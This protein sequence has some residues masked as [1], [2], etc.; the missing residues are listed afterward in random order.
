VRAG[1]RFSARTATIRYAGPDTFP[2][3]YIDQ[4]ACGYYD[5]LSDAVRYWRLAFILTPTTS[6]LARRVEYALEAV[7]SAFDGERTHTRTRMRLSV[8]L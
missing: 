5:E 4:L 1:E 8:S 6:A 3:N 2:W 7:A